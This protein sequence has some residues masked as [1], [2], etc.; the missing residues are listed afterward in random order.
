MLKFHQQVQT[1]NGPGLVQGWL[2]ERDEEGELVR[3]KI[4]VSHAKPAG[5]GVWNLVAYPLEQLEEGDE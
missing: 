2:V 1:P 3:R 4:L 5:G